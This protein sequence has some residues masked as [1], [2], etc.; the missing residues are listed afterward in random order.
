[1]TRCLIWVRATPEVPVSTGEE[2]LAL[3]FNH[4]GGDHDDENPDLGIRHL[5]DDP[6][7]RGTTDRAPT[8]IVGTA[9][10]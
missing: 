3:L 8:R 6:V 5:Q 10:G 4:R 7:P 1:M 9:T 2:D